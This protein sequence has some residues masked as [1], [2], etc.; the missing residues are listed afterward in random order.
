MSFARGPQGNKRKAVGL[1]AAPSA[2][3]IFVAFGCELLETRWL[4]TT[5]LGPLLPVALEDVLIAS[6]LVEVSSLD[7]G[8]VSPFATTSPTGYTPAK[9]RAAYNIDDIF[10]AGGS[11]VGDG[12]GQTIA[13]ID[14]FHTPTALA[15]LTS[16]SNHFGLPMPPSFTQVAQDGTTNYPADANANWSLEAL[17]DIQWAHA[18]APGAS[19]LLVEAA[20]ASP[21]NLGIAI[22]YARSQA[23]VS[24]ISLSWGL[25]EYGTESNYDVHFAT[26]TNHANVSYFAATGDDG[27]PGKYPAYSPGVMA[28]GGTTLPKDGQGNPVI[29]N[30]SSWSGSGGGISL[31]ESQPSWQNGVVTQSATQR[32]TP[33]VAFDANPNTGVS[34]YDSYNNNGAAKWTQVGGT[35]FSAPA[36]AG[37]VAIADQGRN[38]AGLPTLDIPELMTSI[39]AMPSNYFNDIT[40]SGGGPANLPAVGYDLVTGRGTPKSDL[41]VSYLVGMNSV[42]GTV[43]DDV[44]GNTVLDGELGLAGWNVFADLDEDAVLDPLTVGNFASADVPKSITSFSTVTSNRIVSGVTGD[45]TDVNVTLNISHS[46]PSDLIVTLISPTGTRV[47]LANH[48][49]NTADNFTN[50]TFDDSAAIS[51]SKGIGPFS[52]SYHPD[53]M[54]L[55][56]FSENPNGTW[57]L[58]IQDTVANTSGTLNSWSLELTTGDR[59]TTSLADG[60][61]YLGDLPA[62]TYQVRQELQAPY[63]QTAPLSV[64]YTIG[65]AIGEQV[66]GYDFGNQLPVVNSTVDARHIFYNQS[67]FDGNSAAI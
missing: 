52:G 58:E 39:Y 12:T 64:F 55:A 25:D 24:V 22:D 38:L 57:Q 16:F 61:Y 37:I 8:V 21:T 67:T 27:A 50:T 10:F 1:R 47:T 63:S 56:L 35:S 66:T 60:S 29:A 28:V 5:D 65:L 49:G 45:V 46:R 34:V 9:I 13:I 18:I 7:E 26:P 3:T 42:A 53:E 23:G 40:I 48:A 20:S 43:F 54:L 62:G 31:F 2:R 36:W 6:P 15:D 14:A 44:N 51:I 17:L 11:I 32:T 33:D 30:E 4:L 59:S 19:I 41:I